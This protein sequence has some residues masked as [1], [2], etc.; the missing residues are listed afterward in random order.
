MQPA[1]QAPTTEQQPPPKRSLFDI[2]EAYIAVLARVDEA[3]GEVDDMVASELDALTGDMQTK[4]EACKAVYFM[5]REEA[6]ACERFV[7][8][9]ADRAKRKLGQAES[10]RSRLF[11]A[12]LILNLRKVDTATGCAAIQKSTPSL[13][14][15]VPETQVP[16]EFT[17]TKNV[18]RKDLITAALKGGRKLEFARL[19]QSQHLRFR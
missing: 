10:I 11:N 2:V 9:Y 16:A 3:D 15:L 8:R 5:L 14:L 18:V 17:E 4:A 1:E 12:M 6:E 19:K 13:E 7:Q